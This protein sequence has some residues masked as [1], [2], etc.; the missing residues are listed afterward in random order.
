MTE[1]K[2]L[3]TACYTANDVADMLEISLDRFYEIRTRLH[4]EQGMPRSVSIGRL[5]F[6][7]V[8]IEAWLNRDHPMAARRRP[9]NDPVPLPHPQSD[10]EHRDH[11]RIAYSRR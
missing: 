7:K 5:R 10:D 9:D 2:P 1:R 8:A 3:P 11:L 4:D 6:P